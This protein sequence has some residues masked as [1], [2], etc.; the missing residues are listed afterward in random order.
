MVRTVLLAST[1]AAC[2][3]PTLDLA[4]GASTS[5]EWITYA[6]ATDAFGNPGR[7]EVTLTLTGAVADDARSTLID[8]VAAFSTRC[9]GACAEEVELVAAWNGQVATRQRTNARLTDSDPSTPPTVA[10]W[11]PSAAPPMGLI[12]GCP[13]F[14]VCVGDAFVPSPKEKEPAPCV[15]T[16]LGGTLSLHLVLKGAPANDPFRVT[17]SNAT[18]SSCREG[19]AVGSD[20]TFSGMAEGRWSIR[21]WSLTDPQRSGT[22]TVAVSNRQLVTEASVF[23]R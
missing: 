17:L 20:P 6:I 12:P 8:G 10:P 16:S 13:A 7:G 18:T 21:V 11:A 2:T 23:V 1:L 9:D 3:G 15:E 5:T 22:A 4:L 19:I 14:S